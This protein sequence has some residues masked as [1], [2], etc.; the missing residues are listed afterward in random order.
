MERRGRCWDLGPKDKPSKNDSCDNRDWFHIEGLNFVTVADDASMEVASEKASVRVG[1]RV[2]EGSSVLPSCFGCR[3]RQSAVLH[4]MAL[5]QPLKGREAQLEG[6][7]QLL[8][9]SPVF[10]NGL[11]I[12]HEADPLL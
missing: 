12:H 6:G 4:F 2:S 9:R 3:L 1:E 8:K 11:I 5:D 7:D 10:L